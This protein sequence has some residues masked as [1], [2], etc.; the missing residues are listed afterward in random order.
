MRRLGLLYI[1]PPWQ[2]EEPALGLGWGWGVVQGNWLDAP[3]WTPTSLAVLTFWSEEHSLSGSAGPR[4][5]RAFFLPVQESS[6]CPGETCNGVCVCVCECDCVCM[7]LCVCVI[8]CV[9][10]CVC[11]CVC[12]GVCVCVCVCVCMGLHLSPWWRERIAPPEQKIDV[13]VEWIWT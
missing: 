3:W 9:W 8:V 10:E 1:L 13:G 12:M 5:P 2:V 7:G 6:W 11:D 4:K